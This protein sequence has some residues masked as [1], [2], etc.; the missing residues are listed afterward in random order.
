MNQ[1]FFTYPETNAEFHSNRARS[2]YT[3]G[4]AIKMISESTNHLIL[5]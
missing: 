5:F 4:I 1:N 2:V 3:E